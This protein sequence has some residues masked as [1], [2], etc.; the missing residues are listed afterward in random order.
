MR[1][2][3]LTADNYEEA[4][5]AAIDCLVKR[6]EIDA[7]KIAIYALSFGSHWGMRIAAQDHRVAACAAKCTRVHPR[8]TTLRA[9]ANDASK[10]MA[11]PYRMCEPYPPVPRTLRLVDTSAT[12]LACTALKICT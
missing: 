9:N 4:A 12:R 1:G 2:I 7:K 5:S 11:V 3:K 6:P 10:P 8:G